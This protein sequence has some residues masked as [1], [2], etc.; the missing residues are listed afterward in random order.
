MRVRALSACERD[1][2][3][4][5]RQ[6][7]DR[8]DAEGEREGDRPRRVL[9]RRRPPAARPRLGRD[10]RDPRA[11]PSR[12]R[13][14]PSSSWTTPAAGRA[15]SNPNYWR[16][17]RDACRPYDGPALPLL[18]TACK[19][20][21]GTYWAL[22]AW[23]RNLPMRGFEPWTDWQTRRRAPR[24]ALERRPAGPPALPALDLRPHSSGALRPPDVPRPAGLRDEDVVR[25]RAGRV[26]A[27][28]LHRHAQLR[29]RPR[30]EARHRD[31]DAH[32]QRRVLLLVRPPEAPARLSERGAERQRPRRDAPS[33]RDRPRRD[34][35]RAGDDPE[36]HRVRRRR[37]AR[38]DASASTRS[39][40]TTST[41]RPNARAD[42]ASTRG[43]AAATPSRRSVFL[44]RCTTGARLQ[45][46]SR[47]RRGHARLG[48]AVRRRRRALRCAPTGGSVARGARRLLH[49]SQGSFQAHLPVVP[50]PRWRRSRS[51]V[52]RRGCDR[53]GQAFG[54]PRAGRGSR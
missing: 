9:D 41:A 10:R 35:D 42:R 26:V 47:P 13:P 40:A 32:G 52:A 22:Q 8:R 29:L 18:I 46:P 38:R 36:A 23:Q 33:P 20:P 50:L 5:R 53:S 51:R 21:D 31:R 2:R 3:H 15:G 44:V 30:L 12:R 4:L 25:R 11:R 27:Q 54:P 34:P 49:L 17:F 1:R 48:L 7:R 45:A 19:A 28:R 6:E 37:A 39:S 43:D 14:R 16:T 24:L